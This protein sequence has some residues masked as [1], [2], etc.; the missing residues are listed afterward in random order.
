MFFPQP[1]K[2]ICA[3]SGL[4]CLHAFSTGS[5]DNNFNP[6]IFEVFASSMHYRKSAPITATRDESWELKSFGDYTTICL[7]QNYLRAMSRCVKNFIFLYDAYFSA[8]PNNK[9]LIPLVCRHRLNK[10]I[11]IFTE[12]KTCVLV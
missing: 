1:A 12:R 7:D 8:T 11:Q 5:K 2:T 3:E 6:Q 9:P 10:P 4:L